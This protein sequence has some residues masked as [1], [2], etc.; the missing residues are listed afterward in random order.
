M[1][2]RDFLLGAAVAS[3]AFGA[4]R[5][6]LAQS[7][8]EV[9]VAVAYD[10]PSPAVPADFIGLSYESALLVNADYFSPD[11]HSV[12]GLLR[13]L[14]ANGVLRIGGNTSERTFW[15]IPPA[16][17]IPQGATYVITPAAIDALAALMR[18][19]DWRL[20]Y[21]LNLARGTPE[22]AAE[23]A[24]YVARA[25]GPHLAAFQISNEPDGFGKWSAVRPANYDVQALI[26]E[27]RPF[28]AAIRARVPDAKF[29]GPAVAGETAWIA[30]FADATRDSLVMLTRHYYSDGPA[31]AAHINLPK[32]LRSAHQV[33]PILADMGALSRRYALPYRIAETNSIFAEGHPGVS[34][35]FGS[36]LWGLELMFQIAQAGG[37]GINFH[38]GDAKAYTPIG[39]SE[40]GRHLARPLYY[41]M[42]MFKEAASGGAAPLPAQRGPTDVNFAAY[43]MR[44]RD[45]ALR[46]CLINKDPMK[47]TRVRIDAGRRFASAAVTRMTASAVGATSGVMLGGA[48]VDDFGG[49]N[50]KPAGALQPG[51]EIV[52]E[53]PAKSAALV[54]CS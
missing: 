22:A 30:P 35:T 2:R 5:A 40:G 20:I 14:G 4:A 21:G 9:S 34:D 17:P 47:D 44:A 38:T 18:A 8:A 25:V 28:Y 31:R 53:V 50:P 27:W 48:A 12:T 39:A 6:G 11:N 45:G 42:L 33:D 24:E 13:T 36:G 51:S 29:A 7:P 23:E 41:G 43:A 3:G 15:R 26:A 49:W 52:V 16:V 46:V 54:S 37:G 10:R 19:L 32:L 1:N